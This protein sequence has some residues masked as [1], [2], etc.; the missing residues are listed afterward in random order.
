M[1]GERS[2]II[3][4]IIVLEVTITSM[5]KIKMTQI[6]PKLRLHRMNAHPSNFSC[7]I[8]VTGTDRSENNLVPNWTK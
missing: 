1:E 6:I 5:V 7:K 8:F 2:E 4:F 3:T